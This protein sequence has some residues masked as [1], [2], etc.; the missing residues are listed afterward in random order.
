MDNFKYINKKPTN[1]IDAKERKLKFSREVDDVYL[2]PMFSITTIV[3]NGYYE[4][5]KAIAENEEAT[6]VVTPSEGYMLPSSVSVTGASYVYDSA[7]GTITLSEPTGPVEVAVV[8]A[9]AVDPVLANNSWAKI[10]AVCEA[11][12]ASAYWSLGDTK[13]DVG[14]DSVTRTMRICDMQG[15]YGKHVVFEQV[16][17]EANAAVWNQSSNTD[18][19]SCYNN[20]N[21]SYMRNTVLPALLNNYSASLS[22]EITNTTYKV[23]KNGNNSTILDLTDKLFLPAEKEIFGSATYS[24]TE[25]ASAL[26]WF[27]LYQANNTDAFRIKYRS[28]GAQIWWERSPRSGVTDLVCYV[29][30]YGSADISFANLTVGVAP[31]FAF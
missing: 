16:E 3:T 26:T 22:S 15:L 11:G 23:A 24:R 30:R 7:T 21:I 2:E 19:D 31:C 5:P 9:E 8:C 18:D 4:G 12:N 17:Q 28:G 27:A 13:T 6:I 29:G 20:Y 25:E 10:R 14:T 1:V